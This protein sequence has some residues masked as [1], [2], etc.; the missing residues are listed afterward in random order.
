MPKVNATVRGL[1]RAGVILTVMQIMGVTGN[2][3]RRGDI[4]LAVEC[5][6]Q[7]DALQLD[8]LI[9]DVKKGKALQYSPTNEPIAHAKGMQVIIQQMRKI[10]GEKIMLL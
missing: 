3:D 4:Q 6:L 7:C 9:E 10:Q 8:A 1:S 5:A 2:D